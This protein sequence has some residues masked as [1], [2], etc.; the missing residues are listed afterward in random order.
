LS[1]K[2]TS[3][4]SNIEYAIRDVIVH[5]KQLIKDGKK[6]YYL[7]I[8]D[9]AA[10]DLTVPPHVKAALCKALQEDNNYYSPSE[11]LLELREA[12]AKKEKRVNNVNITAGDVLI[13]E[14]ISEGIQ[15][16]RAAIVE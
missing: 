3:R 11:G 5:T 2:V 10:F 6:I 13:T 7:N 15:M 14:G 8:G 12:V 4:A 16:S 9:P 1:F